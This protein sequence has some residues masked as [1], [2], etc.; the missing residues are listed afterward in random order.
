[1][2]TAVDSHN[3]GLPHSAFSTP[4]VY[5][6]PSTGRACGCSEY[7]YGATT[8]DTAGSVPAAQSAMNCASTWSTLWPR[9]EF[10]CQAAFTAARSAS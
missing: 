6:A 2:N 9:P 5:A 10:G 8:Q 4:C 3:D 7:A 1:M